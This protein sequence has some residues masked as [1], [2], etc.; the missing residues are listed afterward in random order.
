MC[1]DWVMTE[2]IYKSVLE[3]IKIKKS[4]APILADLRAHSPVRLSTSQLLKLA[5]HFKGKVC[6]YLSPLVWLVC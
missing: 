4:V 2:I 3:A 5:R 1:I 6:I